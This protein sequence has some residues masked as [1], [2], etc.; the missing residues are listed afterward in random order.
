MH[1]GIFRC[2][3]EY[4][5]AFR[6]IVMHSGIFRYIPEYCDAFRNIQMHS[7]IFRCI[8][9]YSEHSRIFKCIPEYPDAL[10][11]ILIIPEYP[12]ALRNILPH[13]RILWCIPECAYNSFSRSSYRRNIWPYK[14]S[15]S[16]QIKEY[17]KNL[18]VFEFLTIDAFCCL[19]HWNSRS[20]K[21]FQC[22]FVFR[23]ELLKSFLKSHDK[24][25]FHW[26]RE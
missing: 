25:S 5:D 16:R 13:S 23:L 10:R 6:N 14:N 17:S 26:N 15:V 22:C 12:D 20:H 8:P 24:P 9:E 18:F 7:G 11:N 4:S 1:S 3:P 21:T 19:M 2:I